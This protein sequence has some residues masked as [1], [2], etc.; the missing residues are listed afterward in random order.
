MAFS[1]YVDINPAD[2][3]K[4]FSS[5]TAQDRFS[6]SRI[7]K[8]TGLF[9][10]HKKF[11]LTSKSLLPQIAD[12]WNGLSA[13]QKALW[14]TAGSYSGLNGWRCF[15]A[16]MSI[17]LKLGLSTNFTPSNYYQGWFGHISITAPASEIL[18]AQYHPASYYVKHKVAGI[19]GLYEP[20][21]VTEPM[22]LPLQIGISY[23]SNLS[24]TGAT[25]VARFYANVRSSYQ[26]IDRENIL[27]IPFTP[28]T[29]WNTQTATIST[30]LGYVIGYT[31]YIEIV[32]Y[33]GDLYFDNVKAIHSAV[34]WVRDY[35]C[36]DINATFSN[37][38]YQIPKN[39]VALE[40]PSGAVYD[41]DYMDFA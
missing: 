26:G 27:E 1:S 13:G 29:G 22:S 40:L 25:Q 35:K 28:V 7:R 21:E 11:L 32:G 5:L 39:W 41:S 15:V 18:I 10:R 17:R 9:S 20:V 3:Q 12:I 6:F 37:T 33:T 38:Y 8:K 19:K 16:E 30:T 2:E 24:A 14:T 36:S 34:N 23:K 4:F 31:L